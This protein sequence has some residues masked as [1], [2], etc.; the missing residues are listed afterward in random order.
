MVKTRKRGKGVLS[1]KDSWRG[2]LFSKVVGNLGGV[3][4]DQQDLVEEFDHLASDE[5]YRGR[6]NEKESYNFVNIGIH[7]LYAL[8]LLTIENGK[9]RYM[10]QHLKKTPASP[11][12]LVE[13]TLGDQGT[14]L[15]TAGSKVRIDSEDDSP[16]SVKF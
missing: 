4:K 14:I 3:G 13:I 10:V 15:V 6:S 9:I 7:V 5:E 11:P 16:L 2:T 8:G 1:R 12:P